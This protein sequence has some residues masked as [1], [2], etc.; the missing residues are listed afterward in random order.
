MCGAR[1]LESASW[2]SRTKGGSSGIGVSGERIQLEGRRCGGKSSSSEEA[3]DA[4]G[5]VEQ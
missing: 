3:K 1:A 5:N 4:G 2:K